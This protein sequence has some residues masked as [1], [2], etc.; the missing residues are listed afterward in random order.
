MGTSAQNDLTEYTVLTTEQRDFFESNGYL[1]IENAL[2]SD[3]VAEIDAAIDALYAGEAQAG[4]LEA[5][6]NLNVRNCITRHDAFLKLLDWH[7]TA[8]LAWG[9]LNW[10]IQ[11]ITFHLVVLPSKEELP[12]EIRNKIGLHRKMQEL[13]PR[14]LFKIAY[15]ISYQPHPASGRPSSSPEATDSQVISVSIRR[16]ARRGARFR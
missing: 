7:T 8:P 5:G 1:V 11:M 14:I 15:A 16:L 12:P 4:R 6:G 10:N 3:V 9:I 2:P 13:H